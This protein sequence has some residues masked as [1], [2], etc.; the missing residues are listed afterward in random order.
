MLSYSRD[1]PHFA[2]PEA[3]LPFS[4]HSATCSYPKYKNP[5]QFLP[6]SIFDKSL[7]FSFMFVASKWSLFYMIPQR[8]SVHISLISHM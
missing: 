4:Q 8:N 3:A 5:V 1:S 2:E 6:H 7:N